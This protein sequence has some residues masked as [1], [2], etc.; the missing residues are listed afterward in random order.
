MATVPPVCLQASDDED[1]L[2]DEEREA[3]RLQQQTTATM[4]MDDYLPSD[5]DSEDGLTNEARARPASETNPPTVADTGHA[6]HE[7]QE[8]AAL[9][10]ELQS[11]DG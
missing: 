1:A 6:S 2:L 9:L 5:T 3:V 7:A 10:G 4:R 11:A 8:L